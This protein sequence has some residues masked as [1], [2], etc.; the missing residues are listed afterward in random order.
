MSSPES[1]SPEGP[2][3][4]FEKQNNKGKNGNQ[5]AEKTFNEPIVPWTP[6][7][8]REKQEELTNETER[9][10]GWVELDMTQ[11][12]KVQEIEILTEVNSKLKV[13]LGI[14]FDS[15]EKE[16]V[17]ITKK[18]TVQKVDEKYQAQKDKLL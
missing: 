10:I 15:L 13:E 4:K 8:E 2:R 3:K 12:E 5:R 18:K 9:A 11:E 6:T 16:L 1:P 7:Q 17:T 14:L